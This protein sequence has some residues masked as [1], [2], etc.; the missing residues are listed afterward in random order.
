[1]ELKLA[2]L[3]K[4]IFTIMGEADVIVRQCPLAMD[5]WLELVVGPILTMLGLTINTNRLTVA[6]PAKYVTDVRDTINTTWH[7]SRCT[8]TVQEA[9]TLTGKLG[10]LSKG[11]PWVF[12]LLTHLY[13]SIAFALAQNKRLLTE[14]SRK[15]RDVVQSLRTGSYLCS[16]KDQARHISFALKKSAK[17]I[18]HAKFKF[19]INSSMRQE[20]EFFREQLRPGSDILW[21][22]P[23][24]HIIP[25]TPSASFFGDSSLE[26]AGG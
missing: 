20:I 11:A 10:H 14:S 8:F 13:A 19:R 23:I 6:I 1:M 25:R 7:T 21:E 4:A 16:A 3:I 18:H 22:T 5:K 9:H 24:A 12:H 26:G 2:A 17:M 15:F